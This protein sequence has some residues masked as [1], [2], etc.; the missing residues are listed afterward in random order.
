MLFK[1]IEERLAADLILDVSFYSVYENYLFRVV[2]LY[3]MERKIFYAFIVLGLDAGHVGNFH[4]ERQHGDARSLET[5]THALLL[6]REVIG[7]GEHYGSVK[8]CRIGEMEDVELALVLELVV[9]CGT[10]GNENKD[11]HTVYGGLFLNARNYM[12]YEFVAES[13][14][15]NSYTVVHFHVPI[16]IEAEL[17]FIL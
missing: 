7:I 11:I 15:E 3:E 6:I 9:V 2:V 17:T 5:R 4:L 8:R 14:G 12:F 16:L 1:N 13:V 10:I